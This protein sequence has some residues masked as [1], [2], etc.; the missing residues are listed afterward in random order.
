MLEAFARG[1]D[2]L[3]GRWGGP[4]SFRLLIQPAV[5][6]SFAILAGLNDARHGEP[7]FLGYLLRREQWPQIWKHIGKVFIVALILDSIYQGIV[8]G[9]IYAGE[10]LITATFLVVIPYLVVRGTVTRIAR[11][12]GV[13]KQAVRS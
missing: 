8:H 6:I 3:I 4:M 11:A 2:D 5:A 9:G 12:A 1:W 10:L 13:G 7:P